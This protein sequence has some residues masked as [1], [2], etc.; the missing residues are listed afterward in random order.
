[1]KIII[2]PYDFSQSADKACNYAIELAK[3]IDAKIVL[4]H[5]LESTVLYSKLP[6][7]TAQL[8]YAYLYNG[9]VKKLQAYHKKISKTAGKIKIELL[10][11]K[12][13][14]SS[15]ITELAKEKKASFIVMGTTG[16][17]LAERVMMGSNA[18]R[19]IRNAPCMVLAIPPKAKYNGFKKIIYATDLSKDNLASIKRLILFGKLF[20]SKIIFINVG[21]KTNEENEVE[22]NNI[23]PK[24]QEIIHYSKTPGYKVNDGNVINAID[25]FLK[26]NKADCL[27][28]YTRHRSIFSRLFNKSITKSLAI[29]S[30]IP[31]LVIHQNDSEINLPAK[32][33]KRK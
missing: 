9:A 26:T 25:Q 31:L 3:D 19:T 33:S 21:Q 29:H 11:K 16:K 13:L 12:G 4:I 20:K 30:K 32:K 15:R 1:M 27:A 14:P 7:L 24:N 8:D 2:V 6:M 28:V 22:Y 23:K 18:S 5:A 10:I 17:G